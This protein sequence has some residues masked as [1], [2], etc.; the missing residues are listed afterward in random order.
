MR[1]NP[2]HAR[3]FGTDPAQ[4]EQA[5]TRLFAGVL[6][7]HLAKGRI[8]GAFSASALVGVCSMVPPGHCQL[9]G[10]DKIRML[11]TLIR[12]GGLGAALRTMTWAT[13]W[14]RHDPPA[15][16]WHLGPIGVE[17]VLQGQGIG[18]QLLRAFCAQMDAGRTMAYLETDKR[19]NVAIYERFGFQVVGE[20][21]V[22]GIPNWFMIRR[23]A[24]A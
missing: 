16:H 7:G 15:S 22:L 12:A 3:A 23:A 6:G 11:P 2:I 13:A 20:D 17:R 10:T 19:D 1:D 21:R 5:L 8:L 24:G 9:S 18:G 14:A 4:R